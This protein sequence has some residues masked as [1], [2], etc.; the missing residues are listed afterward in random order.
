MEYQDRFGRTINYLRISVTDRCNLRCVY[1]MPPEGV[2]WQPHDNILRYEEIARI[3]SLA[4]GL[5][6]RNIRLTGGEPLV[7]PYLHRLVEMLHTIPGVSEIT[8]TTNGLL[9]SHHARNLAVAGLRRVNISLDTLKPERFRAITRLGDIAQLWEGVAAAEAAGLTPIKFNVVVV[10]GL[11]DDELQDM[12][13]LTFDHTWHIR[14]IELMPIANE[15]DWGLGLPPAPQRYMPVAK[16]R[17]EVERLG[18]LRRCPGPIGNGPA[19]A[20]SLPGALGTIG[21][22]SPISEHFC[23]TCNRLRLTADGRLRLCLLA[24]TEIDLRDP[25]RSGASD[26]DLRQLLRQAILAKP[27]QHFLAADEKPTDRF[28]VQIGG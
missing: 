21:F 16:I 22:I 15:G 8:M 9:L 2:P 18:S 17:A 4:A 23:Q 1:C 26:E 3:A 5:G 14:F 25:L 6:L 19:R 27:A 20:F 28:M 11:N 7:R 13:R 12:A 24:D 10:Q